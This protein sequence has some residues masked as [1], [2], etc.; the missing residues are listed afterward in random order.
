MLSPAEQQPS[1]RLARDPRGEP[2][3]ITTAGAHLHATYYSARDP[4]P[5]GPRL[6]M[7]IFERESAHDV[8]GR[9]A[10]AL[11]SAGYP[12]LVVDILPATGEPEPD[13][14][15]LLDSARTGLTELRR[16]AAP[17]RVVLAAGVSHA[18]LVARCAASERADGVVLV[19]SRLPPE[20]QPADLDVFHLLEPFTGAALLLG[21]ADTESQGPA[22]GALAAH[23]AGCRR[24]AAA[25]HVECGE[26]DGPRATLPVGTDHHLEPGAYAGVVVELTRQW[27]ERRVGAG[28]PPAWQGRPPAREVAPPARAEGIEVQV[29]LLATGAVVVPVSDGA[30]DEGPGAW[31]LELPEGR[32]F[33]L[34]DALRRLVGLVDG[35]RAVGAIATELSAA[36]GRPISAEQVGHLL[37]ERLAPLGV[38]EPDARGEG[39]EDESGMTDILIRCYEPGDRLRAL[40][41][42][43]TKVTRSPYNVVLVVGKRHAA[44]NQNL[45][46]DRALTRYAVF[47]DDD[48]LLTEGWLER[49]RETMDRTGAGAVSGRQLSIDGRALY[50][51]AGCP[52]GAI[53]EAPIGGTCF[54]FRTDLGLRFDESYVRSQW[55]DVDFMFQLFEHGFKTY[56]DGRVPFYH[57][58]EGK[59]WLNQNFTHFNQKWT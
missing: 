9:L 2:V 17:E 11:S 31:R 27:L 34:T 22:A 44:R 14:G 52:E 25:R 57:Y 6:A 1:R 23:A 56:V 30:P 41:D 36:V 16:R 12:A 39:G 49:L 7:L 46:L 45:A 47:L 50:S 54:M 5:P 13:P 3:E 32:A 51:S 33:A 35:H 40:L 18:A 8:H 4:A 55:D 43:L 28:Y 59:I 58:A 37:R 38:L 15:A 10:R 20:G 26:I 48:I 53:V 42:N 24:A 19:G 21:A 29:P